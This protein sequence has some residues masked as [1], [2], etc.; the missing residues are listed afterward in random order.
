ML[1]RVRFLA[2]ALAPLVL[3]PLLFLPV[4]RS[5]SPPAPL[6]RA[7]LPQ[8][9]LSPGHCTWYCHNH[10]CP[11]HPVLPSAL[12]G[13]DGLFGWTVEALHSG[14]DAL[15]P[16]TPGVGYGAVN[17]AVFC[18]A[19]PAGMYALWLVALQQRRRI[20]GLRARR[21]AGAA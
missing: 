21:R 11:H 19:W 6:A 14:G 9:S 18:A 20:R 12:S 5:G 2:A 7:V 3:T 8:E 1:A 4:L 15:S 16:R 10:G 17:L 13:D